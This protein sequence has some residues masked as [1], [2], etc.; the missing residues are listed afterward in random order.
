VQALRQPLLGGVAAVA[1]ALLCTA[2]PAYADLL[3]PPL[4]SQ[5]SPSSRCP[6]TAVLEHAAQE[7]LLLRVAESPVPVLPVYAFA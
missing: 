7:T 1:A 4:A 2:Q 5:S 6:K 3:V